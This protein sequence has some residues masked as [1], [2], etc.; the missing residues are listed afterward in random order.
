MARLEVK[1]ADKGLDWYAEASFLVEKGTV[2]G[3][4]LT[5]KATSDPRP[6]IVRVGLQEDLVKGEVTVVQTAAYPAPSKQYKVP[7]SL[8]KGMSLEEAGV[9]VVEEN[10]IDVFEEEKKEL[11][12]R[13]DTR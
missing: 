13:K 1:D 6:K 12:E 9:E 2:T 8:K 4:E 7:D 10:S 3:V 5:V 11:P